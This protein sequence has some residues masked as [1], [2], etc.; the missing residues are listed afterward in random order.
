MALVGSRAD[1][2]TPNVWGVTIPTCASDRIQP[3][4]FYLEEQGSG[5]VHDTASVAR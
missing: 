5:G 4:R 3:G 1:G 2:S